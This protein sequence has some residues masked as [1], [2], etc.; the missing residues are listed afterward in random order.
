MRPKLIPVLLDQAPP[1]WELTPAGYLVC[2]RRLEKQGRVEIRPRD[3]KD[4]VGRPLGWEW[5]RL[6]SAPRRKAS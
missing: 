3:A 5:R 6:R 4:T 1:Q 2:L